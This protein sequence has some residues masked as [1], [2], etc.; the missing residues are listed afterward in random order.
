[1]CFDLSS[2]NGEINLFILFGF[3]FLNNFIKK[4]GEINKNNKLTINIKN[5][6]IE[7]GTRL[8]NSFILLAEKTITNT[9]TPI[10]IEKSNIL[11]TIKLEK[12]LPTP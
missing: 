11:A 7:Y 4:S 3:I 10:I 2:L 5:T 12:L 8:D 6:I 9:K 1:M